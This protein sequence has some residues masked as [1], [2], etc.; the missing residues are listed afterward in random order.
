MAA[1]I[2]PGWQTEELQE[3][4]IDYEEDEDASGAC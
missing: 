4:W 2:L 1:V 3:E